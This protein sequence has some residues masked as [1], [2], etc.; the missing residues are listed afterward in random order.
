MRDLRL[1]SAAA[2][3]IPRSVALPRRLQEVGCRML[4]CTTLQYTML[5]CNDMIL[6]DHAVFSGFAPLVAVV[7]ECSRGL[8]VVT[9][10]WEF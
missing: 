8:Q 9:G 2:K 6:L 4:Q 3:G 7:S 10:C 1:L 5:Y